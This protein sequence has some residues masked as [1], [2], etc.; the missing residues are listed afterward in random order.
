MSYTRRTPYVAEERNT[1]KSHKSLELV[2]NRAVL[3]Y[4]TGSLWWRENNH[5]IKFESN[6]QNV[7]YN[8]NRLKMKWC[9]NYTIF[10]LFQLTFQN[11]LSWN[12]PLTFDFSRDL[13]LSVQ[14]FFLFVFK[15]SDSRNCILLQWVTITSTDTFG[16]KPLPHFCIGML[17]I[18]VGP[19]QPSTVFCK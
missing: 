16:I 9:M 4:D 10:F 12:N 17:A 18:T 19:R 8:Q 5:W 3:F 6:I 7:T 11:C 2:W 1:I 15:R 13:T 14:F